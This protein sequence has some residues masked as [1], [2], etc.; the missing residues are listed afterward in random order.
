MKKIGIFLMGV[1]TTLILMGLALP[2]LASGGTV[3]WDDVFVGVSLVIN[4][5]NAEAED[6]EGNPVDGVIYKGV[7]YVPVQ[8]VADALDLPLEWD[9]DSRTVYLGEGRPVQPEPEP[10]PAGGNEAY[11]GTYMLYSLMEMSVQ[12]MADMYGV[13]AEFFRD[14]A[15]L[16]LREDGTCTF[17]MYDESHDLEWAVDG[18]VFTLLYQGLSFDGTIID[19]IISLDFDGELLELSMTLPEPEPAPAPEPGAE[20]EPEEEDYTG[21]YRLESMWG[22]PVDLCAGLMEV[23]VEEVRDLMVLEL[24]EDGTAIFAIEGDEIELS[25][26]VEDGTLFLADETDTL[27][28][29]IGDGNITLYLDEDMDVILS[30]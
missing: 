18:E 25:W 28:A 30:K 17:T 10:E 12:D 7:T 22:L 19:G 4:G 26:W 3:T 24:R 16:E 21:V 15:V 13:D 14:L 5:E 2:A 1:F 23:E 27:E 6:G 11:V 29:D 9:E 20:P 8:A